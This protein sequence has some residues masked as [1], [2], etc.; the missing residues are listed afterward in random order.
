MDVRREKTERCPECGAENKESAAFCSLCLKRFGEPEPAEPEPETQ[1]AQK[2]EPEQEKADAEGAEP[3]AVVSLPEPAVPQGWADEIG[4]FGS[5][6]P[7]SQ[8][9]GDEV[10][11]PLD[12]RLALEAQRAR[13]VVDMR[14]VWMRATLVVAIVISAL[15]VSITMLVVLINRQTESTAQQ[16]P[17]SATNPSP[18][19]PSQPQQQPETPAAQ[20]N[21]SYTTP[22]GWTAGG[23]P[24][25]IL[26]TSSDGSSTI[27][28]RAWP[29]SAD[30]SYTFAGTQLRSTNTDGLL[31]EMQPLLL[32]HLYG[33]AVPSGASASTASAGSAKAVVADSRGQAGGS[34]RRVYGFQQ[35]DWTYLAGGTA[36]LEG[37]NELKRAMDS[38][39]GSIM[40]G[41]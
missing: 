28:I 10:E 4:A 19:A 26:L 17:T 37:E 29:R 23:T 2:S 9:G 15:A 38:L 8:E 32:A 22:A 18:V 1:P 11:L 20:P 14:R 12:F 3:R 40:F 25:D 34:Y 35:G 6:A 27:E 36:P 21:L 13:K 31:S 16:P 41:R 30:G 33:T 24:D 39:T 5:T 7:P